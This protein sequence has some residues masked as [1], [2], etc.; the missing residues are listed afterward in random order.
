MSV[1]T[2]NLR[3]TVK[4]VVLSNYK[5]PAGVINDFSCVIQH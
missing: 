1:V 2:D 4:E 3:T 5:V